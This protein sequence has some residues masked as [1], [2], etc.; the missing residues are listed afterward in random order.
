MA[1]YE[2]S[3]KALND[4]HGIWFS[5]ASRWGKKQ[6]DNYSL[7]IDEMC[8]FLFENP[9]LGRDKS[10][11]FDGL[12]SYP[13]GSHSIYYVEQDSSILV[14]RILHQRMDYEQHLLN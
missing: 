10:E 12:K 14:V 7:K 2:L 1:N 11:V 4:L 6:A 8:E 9:G 5:G 13:V 3:N